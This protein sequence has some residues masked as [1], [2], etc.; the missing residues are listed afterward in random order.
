MKNKL[1]LLLPLALLLVLTGCSE[2]NPKKHM[3]LGTWNEK[4]YVNEFA[5]LTFTVPADWTIC[6]AQ[7][8]ENIFEDNIAKEMLPHYDAMVCSNTADSSLMLPL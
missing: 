8:I 3:A 1:G 5:E 2:S 6:T 4:T 7:D